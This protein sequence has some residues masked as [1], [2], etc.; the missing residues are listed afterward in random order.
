VCELILTVDFLDLLERQAV[1]LM[2]ENV[3]NWTKLLLLLQPST[4]NDDPGP[5]WGIRPHV[6]FHF[7]RLA[8]SVRT[9]N[10]LPQ[11]T[12]TTL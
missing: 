9:F 7:L 3:K 1:K 4:K 8:W 11:S 5:H 12:Y 6:C 10:D 2:A